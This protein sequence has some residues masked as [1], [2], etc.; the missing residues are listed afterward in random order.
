M[1]YGLRLIVVCVWSVVAFDVFFI[2]RIRIRFYSLDIHAF[3]S[4]LPRKLNGTQSTECEDEFERCSSSGRSID[5]LMHVRNARLSL[6]MTK[7]IIT[8]AIFN[9]IFY[10]RFECFPRCVFFFSSFRCLFPFV[11]RISLF[12]FF[13]S[14]RL[15]R[16]LFKYTIDNNWNNA[17]RLALLLALRTLHHTTHIAPK[18]K[19]Y[20][21]EYRIRICKPHLE[22]P[23]PN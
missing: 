1:I 4:A 18:E 23:F 16:L 15:K 20:K 11:D 10:A 14:F 3:F 21:F 19:N 9:T 6:P 2:K 7:V 8:N 17:C 22:K 5:R 12:P 13:S